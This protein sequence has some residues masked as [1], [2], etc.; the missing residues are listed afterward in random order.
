MKSKSLMFIWFTYLSIHLA[1]GQN[2]T[3]FNYVKLD[4]IEFTHKPIFEEIQK[5]VIP[6]LE[7]KRYDA[8]K[9]MITIS[10]NEY[11]KKYKGL[12]FSII[13]IF[14]NRDYY[15]LPD[16][17]R[18]EF[19]YCKIKDFIF[20]ITGKEAHLY[21]KKSKKN[22]YRNIKCYSKPYSGFDGV[23]SWMYFIKGE[24][25]KLIDHIENW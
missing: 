19:G 9:Y 25:I 17:D 21:A 4:S 24:Q 11:S 16:F 15:Q 8:K 18:Y 12:T 3:D 14:D 1:Y 10:F 13:S 22:I 20:I 7:S 23:I 2:K 6:F 5:N